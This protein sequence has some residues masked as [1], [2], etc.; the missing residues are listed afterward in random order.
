M[1]TLLATISLAAL[2]DLLALKAS[3]ADVLRPDPAGYI[4]HWVMLAPIPLPGEETCTDAILKQQIKNEAELRPKADDKVTI[5]GK[6]LSWQ[7]VIASTNYFD[8][9]AVLK[10]VND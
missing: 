5:N 10:R 3:A 7:N 4:R 6:E 1:K 9:N 8:F 2:F